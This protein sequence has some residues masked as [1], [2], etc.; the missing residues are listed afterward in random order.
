MDE[1]AGQVRFIHDVVMQ[2]ADCLCA[3]GGD[4]GP[5]C[6]IHDVH[7]SRSSLWQ[8]ISVY[9]LDGRHPYVVTDREEDFIEPLVSGEFDLRHDSVPGPSRIAGGPLSQFQ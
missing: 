8:Q 2:D 9:H 3:L 4:G 5:I 1:R 6:A 7:L